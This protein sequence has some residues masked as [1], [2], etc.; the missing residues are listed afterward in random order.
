MAT[1]ILGYDAIE[2]EP[3]RVRHEPLVVFDKFKI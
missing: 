1:D 3:T 2:H